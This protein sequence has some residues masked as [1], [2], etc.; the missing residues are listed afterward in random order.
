MCRYSVYLGFLEAQSFL[1]DTLVSST[2]IPAYPNKGLNG[3]CH[4][5]ILS[6]GYADC[7]ISVSTGKFG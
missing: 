2:K 1:Y 5:A 3:H 7:I 6:V 4:Q